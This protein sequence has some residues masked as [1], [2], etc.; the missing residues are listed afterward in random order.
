MRWNHSDKYSYLI[1][2]IY[3]IVRSNNLLFYE[4]MDLIGILM[5]EGVRLINYF[6]KQV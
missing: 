3:T 1:S 2:Y 6:Y 4:S 5:A